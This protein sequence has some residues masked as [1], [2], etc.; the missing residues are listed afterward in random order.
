M[1]FKFGAH[2]IK[3]SVGL[4]TNYGLDRGLTNN[5]EYKAFSL[6]LNPELGLTYEYGEIF[7]VQPSYRY[8]FNQSNFTNYSIDK[9]RTFRHVLKTELTLRWPKHVVFGADLGYTYN[10]NIA[11]GFRKDFYL[12]NTS[13]GYNFFGDKLLAKIKVYDILNQ[14]TATSRMITPESIIDQQNT[15]LKRYV[16]FSLTYKIEKFAGKKK[17]PWE[18]EE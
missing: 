7:T 8:E 12:L 11:D 9:S 18:T 1:S 3:T 17:N 14:N 4:N 10:A 6:A 15:V 2:K 16:M 13:L 5:K